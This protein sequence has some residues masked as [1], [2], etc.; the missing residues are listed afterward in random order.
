MK[1]LIILVTLLLTAMGAGAKD[2]QKEVKRTIMEYLRNEGYVPTIDSD[3]DI[4]FK[5]TGS[6][7]YIKFYDGERDKPVYLEFYALYRAGEGTSECAV[8]AAVNHINTYYKMV[9]ASYAEVEQPGGQSDESGEQSDGQSDESGEQ[10]GESGGPNLRLCFETTCYTY[11]GSEFNRFVSTYV[12]CVEGG[13]NAFFE[14]MSDGNGTEEEA[15]VL[16]GGAEASG[17]GDADVLGGSDGAAAVSEDVADTSEDAAEA[18]EDELA[19]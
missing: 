13:A 1:N 19:G 17:G 7:F 6:Q 9:R 14:Y 8:A 3:G 2:R 4:A 16:D 11:D 10:A 15:D 12:N 18:S 5:V